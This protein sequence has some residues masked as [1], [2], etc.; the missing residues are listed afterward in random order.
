MNSYKFHEELP[1]MRQQGRVLKASDHSVV[2]T[3]IEL[4]EIAKTEAQK[5]REEAEVEWKLQQEMGYRQGRE[6]ARRE[7]ILHHWTIIANTVSYL[8]VLQEQMVETILE[9]VRIIIQET[10]A[11]ER[12]LQLAAAAVERLRQQAWVVL[13][14]HPEDLDGVNILLEGWK[15]KCLPKQMRVETRASEEIGKGN[16][17]LESPIG[18]ID[19][20]LDTQ[21]QVIQEQMRGIL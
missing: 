3:A 21:L 10:P 17:V 16:C 8:S 11:S 1:L 12:V 7:A 2:A 20:S 13:C 5:R 14:V 19:A 18:R 9:A 6:Q 4:L 15:K